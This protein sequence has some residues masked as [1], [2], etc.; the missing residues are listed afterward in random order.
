MTDKPR[1]N[2]SAFHKKNLL[3]YVDKRYDTPPPSNDTPQ[4]HTD[5]QKN[6]L[7]LTAAIL[8]GVAV[9]SFLLVIPPVISLAFSVAALI[10]AS[11][12]GT[13][14]K[15]A[16]VSLITSAVLFVAGVG[17]GVALVLSYD[18]EEVVRPPV[19]YSVDTTTGLA[20]KIS[21][22]GQIPCDDEGVC[23]ATVS[24][25]STEDRCTDGGDMIQ[26]VFSTTNGLPGVGTATIPSLEKGDSA[27]V[28][29]L[30]EAPNS[31]SVLLAVAM[32]FRCN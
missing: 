15:V 4:I 32:R 21:P 7:A 24:L 10:T 25:L 20:Y 11:R 23:K 28:E 26:Q 5:E 29:I 9:I 12:R 30:F 27:D 17:V 16:L 13:S 2:D 19:N 18:S 31:D 3:S 22:D 8:T 1:M 6:G 14:K